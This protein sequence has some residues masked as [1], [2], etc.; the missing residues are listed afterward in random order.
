MTSL[1]TLTWVHVSPLPPVWPLHLE[2]VHPDCRG[3]PPRGQEVRGHL[4]LALDLDLPAT[5]ELV[6]VAAQD[7]VDF[8]GAL[9][10]E[11]SKME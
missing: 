6:A 8:L 1:Q 9:E 3:R 11:N 2:V 10:I 5:L 7:V 4:A